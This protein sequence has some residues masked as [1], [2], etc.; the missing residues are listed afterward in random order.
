MSKESRRR[1]RAANPSTS[2]RLGSVDRAGQRP[3]APSSTRSSRTPARRGTARAG[4]RDRGRPCT[5]ETSFLERDA[6]CCSASPS[7]PS[8]CVVGIGIFAASTQ[9]VYACSHRVVPGPDRHAPRG[10]RPRSPGYA[11]PDMGDEHVANGASITYTYCPPASGRH[12]NGTQTGPISARVYGPADDVRPQGWIHNLEHGALVV[13]YRGDS[14]GATDA[15]QAALRAFFDS[16]PPSPVCGFAAGDERR[17]GVRAL[18]RHADAVHGH[19]LGSRAPARDRS[20]PKRSSNSIARTAS[21]PTRRASA[22]ARRP[23][24]ASCPA[25][26]HRRHPAPASGPRRCAST[27]TTDEDLQRGL[28]VDLAVDRA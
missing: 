4:R 1:Q 7:S 28:G 2:R 17:P 23:R 5:S 9:P 6:R 3:A 27:R 11:Q 10:C 21:G 12:Y 8:S 24:R 13:L 25:T 15:G 16:Y 26:R 20:I 19:G 18:R 14:E 22:R